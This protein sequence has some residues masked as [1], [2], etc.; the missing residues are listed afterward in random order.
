[1]R[2]YGTGSAILVPM[3]G[4][5]FIAIQNIKCVVHIYLYIY[6][7][8]LFISKYKYVRVIQTIPHN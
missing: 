8:I 3:R 2:R 7:Y 5:L 4:A 6:N 1:M